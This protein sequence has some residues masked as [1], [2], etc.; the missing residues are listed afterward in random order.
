MTRL[1]ERY[2]TQ[3]PH[4]VRREHQGGLLPDLSGRPL[5]VA[6]VETGVRLNALGRLPGIRS[7]QAVDASIRPP[8]WV[9]GTE[10]ARECR[11]GGPGIDI[12]RILALERPAAV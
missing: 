6:G 3:N 1:S 12:H 8:S 5:R 7:N 9:V 4:P 11:L 10:L 2:E